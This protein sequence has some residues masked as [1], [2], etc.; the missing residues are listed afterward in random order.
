MLHELI[1]SIRHLLLL[2]PQQIHSS[3][4]DLS[5][6]INPLEIFIFG[7]VHQPLDIPILLQRLQSVFYETFQFKPVEFLQIGVVSQSEPVRLVFCYFVV[8]EKQFFE[9]CHEQDRFHC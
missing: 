8:K 2:L 6:R 1:I 3:L 7:R 5:F 9:G 4:L